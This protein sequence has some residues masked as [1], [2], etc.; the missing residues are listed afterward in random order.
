MAESVY[1]NRST[2][3]YIPRFVSKQEINFSLSEISYLSSL[4]PIPVG[5]KELQQK[6][7]MAWEF[8]RSL[9]QNRLL[10]VNYHNCE[11]ELFFSRK[12]RRKRKYNP[13]NGRPFGS[14]FMDDPKEVKDLCDLLNTYFIN[15][16]G[17]TTKKGKAG[18]SFQ[19]KFKIK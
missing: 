7:E 1:S 10:F 12:T 9:A 14:F 15:F 3:I 11:S 2:K 13:T 16:K 18:I 8:I 17:I 6:S 5:D 4:L 19:L